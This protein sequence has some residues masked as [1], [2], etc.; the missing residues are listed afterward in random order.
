MKITIALSNDQARRALKA[1]TVEAYR[2]GVLSATE[3]GRLLGHKS[4]WET[5]SFLHEKQ[6]HLHY[7]EEDLAR[8]METILNVTGQ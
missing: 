3:V 2:D 1:L 8:D 5:E 7:T 4:R 6:A